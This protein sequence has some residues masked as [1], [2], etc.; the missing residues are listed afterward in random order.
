MD[1]VHDRA[2]Q[3][4]I[5]K[6]GTGTTPARESMAFRDGWHACRNASVSADIARTALAALKVA[7]TPLPEDRETVLTAITSLTSALEQTK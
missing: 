4:A 2:F 1:D 3:A 6:W 5:S 7:T